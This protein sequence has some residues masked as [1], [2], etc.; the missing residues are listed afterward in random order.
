M[1]GAELLLDGFSR[2][3]DLVHDVISGMS[4]DDLTWRADRAANP[5]GWLVWHAARVEDDHVAG[6]AAI[7]QVWTTRG[8][9]D[10]FNLPYDVH[11]HGYGQSAA[12]VGEFRVATGQRLVDYYDAV[13]DQTRVVIEGLVDGDF[14]R[15]VDE[16]W[17]PPV[18]LGVRLVSVLGDVTQHL[19]QAAYVRGLI[20]R[21]D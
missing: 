9:V 11:A 10:R 1:T 7:A 12:E 4:P 19:G 6:A 21:R 20:Q 3:K 8:F 18:T 17:N 16:R 13:H 5:I 2:V 15:V 14:D